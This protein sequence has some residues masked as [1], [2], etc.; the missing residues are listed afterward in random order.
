MVVKVGII[1]KGKAKA[2]GK[3]GD[4]M[5]AIVETVETAVNEMTKVIKKTVT[6][7]VDKIAKYRNEASRMASLANK[8]LNRLE[9]NNLQDSPAY[10]GYLEKGGQRFSVRGK[11]YNE[12]QAEVAR[13]KAFI[14]ANTSTVR[15]V[16]NYL[17]EIASNTG[18]KYSNLTELRKKAPKFFE[19]ANKVEQ[20]LRTVEDMAS[21]IGYGKI[22]ES[23]NVYT[24]QNKVDLSASENDVDK[25]IADITKAIVEHEKPEYMDFSNI[26]GAKSQWFKLPK[27]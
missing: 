7:K 19:L 1:P 8:R 10:R 13:M 6:K 12:V 15:G 3:S 20:Y 25:M 23:I 16:N 24:Q 21:A 22:W 4:P 26:D 17:R 9:S 18:I 14:D 27:E 11:S 5:Q 2:M